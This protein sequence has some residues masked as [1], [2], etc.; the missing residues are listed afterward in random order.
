MKESAN[1][2]GR[3]PISVLMKH[4]N[5]GIPAGGR[6]TGRRPT[7]ILAHTIIIPVS[8]I[9]DECRFLFIFVND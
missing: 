5:T 8:V 3:K 2:D 6:C 4:E 9:A 7:W 1:S